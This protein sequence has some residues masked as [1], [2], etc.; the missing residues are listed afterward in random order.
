MP[1]LSAWKNAKQSK[2]KQIKKGI[3]KNVSPKIKH[4]FHEH[5]QISKT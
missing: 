5:T 3:K 2:T 1:S 4:A